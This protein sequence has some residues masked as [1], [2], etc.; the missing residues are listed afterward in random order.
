MKSLGLVLSFL[1]NPSRRRNS[2]ALVKLLFAFVFMVLVFT[3]IFHWLMEMEG[4]KHSWATGIYWV[5]VVMSTFGFGDNTFHSG[6]G[7]LFSVVVLM[8]GSVFMLMRLPFMFI[9]FFYVP[10]LDAQYAARAPS[11][12]SILGFGVQPF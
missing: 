11:T 12:F 9:Q 4:Q 2:L 10:W 7:K 1:A 8:S 3:I 5:L 6:I